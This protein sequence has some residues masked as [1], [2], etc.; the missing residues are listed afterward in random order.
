MIDQ[1]NFLS[2]G[3]YVKKHGLQDASLAEDRRAK[4]LNIN[5]EKRKG[6]EADEGEEE[7]GETELEKAQRELED[8]EDE[9]EE[10]YDPGDEDDSDGSGSSSEEEDSVYVQDKEFADDAARD[11]VKEELGSEA[12]ELSGE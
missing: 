6:D 4:K 7:T 5:S 9:E 11:L 2:I 1:A 12:E 3:A 10:D 8:Q